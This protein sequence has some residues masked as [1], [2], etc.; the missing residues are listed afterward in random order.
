METGEC[1]D[2]V[3]IFY[4][5]LIRIDKETFPRHFLII[6]KQKLMYLTCSNSQPQYRKGC[7]YRK[8]FNKKETFYKRP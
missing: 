3:H 8:G 5:S 1:Y 2:N 6:L 4:D 7:Q